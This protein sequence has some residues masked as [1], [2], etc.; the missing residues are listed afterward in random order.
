MEHYIHMKYILGSVIYSFLGIIILVLAF[1]LM[2]KL[3]PYSLW[4]EIIANQNKAL[5]I[6]AAAFI[7]A[8]A[9][10]IGS[11]IHG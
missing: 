8:I 10:I 9:I 11:A 6:V 1:W 3:T 5:A 2:D 4:K 7:L